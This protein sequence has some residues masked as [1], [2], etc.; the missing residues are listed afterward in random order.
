MASAAEFIIRPNS[1]YHP[2]SW[3]K[4]FLLLVVVCMSIAIRFALLGYWIILPF[5]IIDVVAVGLILQM[6]VRQSSYVEKITVNDDAVTV[7]HIQ[8]NRNS[9]WQFPLHWTQVRLEMPKYKWYP[10]RLL[11]GSKGKWVEVGSCLTDEERNS[12]AQAVQ[13]QVSQAGLYAESN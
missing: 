8:K 3:Y 1:S 10:N 6:V 12:L 5:A 2:K 11:L 4:L 9:D 7:H 13:S